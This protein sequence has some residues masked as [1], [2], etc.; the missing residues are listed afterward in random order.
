[1]GARPTLI[2]AWSDGVRDGTMYI[3]CSAVG[4]V[5]VVLGISCTSGSKTAVAGV[6]SS[7]VSRSEDRVEIRFADCKRRTGTAVKT[8]AWEAW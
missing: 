4:V 6:C 8:S 1:M 3:M 7:G 2:R 5:D